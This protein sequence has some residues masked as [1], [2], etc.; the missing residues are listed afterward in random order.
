MYFLLQSSFHLWLPFQDLHA[1]L[2]LL[3]PAVNKAEHY[4]TFRKYHLSCWLITLNFF[5]AYRDVWI[6]CYWSCTWRETRWRWQLQPQPPRQRAQGTWNDAHL[7]GLVCTYFPFAL[8]ASRHRLTLLSQLLMVFPL[9]S[10]AASGSL[11][12]SQDSVRQEGWETLGSPHL[13]ETLPHGTCRTRPMPAPLLTSKALTH[14]RGRLPPPSA[15]T[16]PRQTFHPCTHSRL[17]QLWRGASA[18]LPSSWATR[19]RPVPVAVEKRRGLVS[20]LV[21]FQKESWLFRVLGSPP[22]AGHIA[23]VFPTCWWNAC[24]CAGCRTWP[25]PGAEGI[26]WEDITSTRFLVQCKNSNQQR[27]RLFNTIYEPSALLYS[28]FPDSEWLCKCEVWIEGLAKIEVK[29]ASFQPAC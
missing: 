7:T 22:P 1:A 6:Y 17:D 25:W 13:R 3:W 2:L 14:L 8:G 21:F 9:S 20:S 28:F 18:L 27:C 23:N 26:R 29:K 15:A 24:E 5:P 10:Q 12:L 4:I 11:A 16:P 19:V